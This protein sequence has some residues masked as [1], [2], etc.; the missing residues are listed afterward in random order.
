M[1]VV[2]TV[3]EAPAAYRGPGVVAHVTARVRTFSFGLTE[4]G[5]ALVT[6]RTAR[7]THGAGR[8]TIGFGE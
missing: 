5:R 4:L 1:K 2:V 7:R 8:V 3:S 6:Y